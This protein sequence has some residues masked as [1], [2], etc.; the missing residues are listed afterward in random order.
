MYKNINCLVLKLKFYLTAL[1][2]RVMPN[3]TKQFVEEIFTIIERKKGLK[4]KSTV[5][6]YN[7]L[8]SI[9]TTNY[10]FNL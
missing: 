8:K 9:C 10:L 4:R 1:M 5:G 7:V 2:K 3:N 6:Q